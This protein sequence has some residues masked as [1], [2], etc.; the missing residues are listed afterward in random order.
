MLLFVVGTRTV[1]WR[2]TRGQR[3]K[4]DKAKESGGVS[5]NHH[6]GEAMK[7]QTGGA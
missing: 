5:N 7:Q 1:I 2:S 3:R 6:E 4:K